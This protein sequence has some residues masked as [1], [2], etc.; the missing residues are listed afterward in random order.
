MGG[1]VG[2]RHLVLVINFHCCVCRDSSQSESDCDSDVSVVSIPS[3][4][5]HPWQ[6]NQITVVTLFP[7]GTNTGGHD[8]HSDELPFK[9]NVNHGVIT[10]RSFLLLL[11]YD[12]YTTLVHAVIFSDWARHHASGDR[13]AKSASNCTST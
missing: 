1:L 8:C 12:I 9:S 10:C 4:K 5:F 11:F 13:D 3:K 2:C 7:H 6:F